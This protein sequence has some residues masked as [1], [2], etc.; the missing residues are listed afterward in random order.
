[1]DST[2]L[3][4]F[5]KPDAYAEFMQKPFING[6]YVLATDGHI[7]GFIKRELIDDIDGL[8]T[9]EKDYIGALDKIKSSHIYN[10]TIKLDELLK[11]IKSVESDKDESHLCPDCQG[12]GVVKFEYTSVEDYHTYTIESGCPVCEGD[13][14]NKNYEYMSTISGW[15]DKKNNAISIKDCWFNPLYLEK[16]L[17]MMY[18]CNVTTCTFVCGE[19]TKGCQFHITDGVDVLIMPVFPNDTIDNV[20]VLNC[21][22]EK[23]VKLYID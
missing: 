2:I 19:P 6:D 4:K 5:C 18:D 12:T 13:G 9:Y 1:M 11:V 8:V 22:D 10:I 16:V 20:I 15:F 21:E 3:K 17:F 7:A 14:S 23:K